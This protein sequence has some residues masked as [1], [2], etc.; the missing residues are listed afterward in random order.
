MSTPQPSPN[1]SPHLSETGDL[2]ERFRVVRDHDLGGVAHGMA[3][4]VDSWAAGMEARGVR[5]THDSIADFV[6]YVN[7]W[8]NPV[9]YHHIPPN[10]DL[11]AKSH[12]ITKIV[13]ESI[14]SSNPVDV[15]YHLPLPVDHYNAADYQ[16][17]NIYPMPRRNRVRRVLDFGAGFGRQ[18]NLW[19]QMIPDPVYCAVDAIA[20][21]YCSQ[22]EYY[23]RFPDVPLF[24]YI[25]DPEGFSM[26]EQRGI[27]HLPTWRFDLLP[28]DF[29]DL[30]ICVHVL[31][32]LDEP[33]I[34]YVLD[35]LTRVLKPGARLYI[36]DHDDGPGHDLDTN[37]E[38]AARGFVME[39]H[40]YLRDFS[41]ILGI[42]RLLRKL[43]P[44][45]ANRGYRSPRACVD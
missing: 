43:D 14:K 9:F 44:A 37:T 26:R 34:Q 18:A 4:W 5:R 32:E 3:D 33:L 24:D 31:P 12:R 1:L 20:N 13:Y 19:T 27:Y 41:D 10:H 23:R 30:A 7:N 38:L 40:P 35:N 6:T 11:V 39:F 15:P 42:P 16:F 8:Y 21:G 22:H 25:D 29:F 28:D 2:G 45:I 17:Q 36:R